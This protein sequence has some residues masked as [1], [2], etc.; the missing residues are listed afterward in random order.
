MRAMKQRAS[1]TLWRGRQLRRRASR[2]G[3]HRRPRGVYAG[4][5]DP[6]IVGASPLVPHSA[7]RLQGVE[8]VW[9]VP[10]VNAQGPRDLT[11]HVWGR[12]GPAHACMGWAV[13]CSFQELRPPDRA[14]RSAALSRRE[15]PPC[16]DRPPLPVCSLRRRHLRAHRRD[17]LETLPCPLPPPEAIP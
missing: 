17:L 13:H 10:C 12:V 15:Q 4:L 5:A 16:S 8:I 7:T 9:T 11:R 6:H 1:R 2:C 14:P 3:G